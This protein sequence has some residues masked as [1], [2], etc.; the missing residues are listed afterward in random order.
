MLSY[1]KIVKDLV[2][3]KRTTMIEPTNNLH[4]YSVIATRSL[5]EKKKYQGA[6]TILS[7][8]GAYDF[9]RALCDLGSSINLM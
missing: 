2:T 7:T 8:I 5:V 4:H 3:K 6:I 1:A 9:A